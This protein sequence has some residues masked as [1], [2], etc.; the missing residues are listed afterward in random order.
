V[1]SPGIF[2]YLESVIMWGT[3]VL[4]MGL[5]AAAQEQSPEQSATPAE[6]YKALVKEFG[7]SAHGLWQAKNDDERTIAVAHGVKVAPPLMDLVEKNSKD[8]IALEA[9][10]QV[11][12]QEVWL[13]NNTTHPG[14]GENSPEV[15]AIAQLL[16]DHVRSEN[17]LEACRRTRY[18]FR[19]ECETFLRTVLEKNPH[20]EI[21][22][23]ASLL[24][25]Q[26]L[27]S[28]LQRLDLLKEQL[29][30]AR[31][32]EG[33]FGKE[34]LDALQRRDRVAAVKEVE[35]AFERATEQFG[36]VK[37]RFGGTVGERAKSELF[38]IRQLAVGKVAQDIEGEDQDGQRFKLSDYRGKVV[39]LY[40]WAEI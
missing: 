26:F 16:R 40:F 5:S 23:N 14:Y 24:L 29:E 31:R 12:M 32:Y 17:L 33:L 13:E 37:L 8:P 38:E 15:R 28:R 30:M 34:Y 6:Q 22:A 21:Q 4:L 9:L 2:T 7:E 39:L 25:A 11:V 10:V 1:T 3:L 20:K 27:N 35:A 36:D 19:K 18:G